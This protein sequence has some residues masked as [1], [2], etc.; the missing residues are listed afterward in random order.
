MRR[1]EFLGVLG[2]SAAAWSRGARAQQPALPV[3]GYLSSA[4]RDR[5]A[6]RLRAFRRGLSETGYVEGH[7]VAIEYRWAEEKND[8]LPALAADLVNRQVTVIVANNPAALPA[9]AATKTIPIVFTIGFDPVAA[10]LVASLNRPGGNLTGL[11]SLNLELGLKRLELMHE[12]VPAATILAFLV[13]PTSPSAE[14]Q[15]RNMEAAVRTMGLQL[16]VLHA[17]T[18][19]DFDTVFASLVQQRAGGLVIGPDAFFNSRTEQL[20]AL[21]LR[22]AVPAIFQFREFAAAGGLVSYGGSLADLYRQSG[23]YTG[24]ILKGEKPA[25]L[26]V[27]QVTKVELILN[28]KT[29]KALGLIVPPTLLARADE[30]IE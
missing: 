25:D 4:A 26:P 17:S 19:A 16:H 12:L 2:G 10:G 8:R 13:N 20:A 5:D 7:N 27:Q 24:R 18:D 23:V 14:T 29:A 30:V 21:A 9:K 22:H 1:R 28:L 15:L 6:G 3:I 11:T